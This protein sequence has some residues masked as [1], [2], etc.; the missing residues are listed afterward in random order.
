[1]DRHRQARPRV[2]GKFDE[3]DGGEWAVPQGNWIF[4]P[5]MNSHR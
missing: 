5:T 2:V 4:R 1:M 3:K